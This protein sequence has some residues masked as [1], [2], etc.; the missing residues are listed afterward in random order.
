MFHTKGRAIGLGAALEP[1]ARP[2][3]CDRHRLAAR[4]VASKAHDLT[5]WLR[6]S[7]SAAESLHGVTQCSVELVY[8]ILIKVNAFLKN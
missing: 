1:R 5:A 7:F 4:T 3:L 6:R 2:S 8:H